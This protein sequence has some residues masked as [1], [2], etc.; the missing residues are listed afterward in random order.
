MHADHVTVAALV[1]IELCLIGAI[2]W[3]QVMGRSEP[4]AARFHAAI[5][6]LLFAS[7]GVLISTDLAELFGFWAIAGAMTYLL[8]AHRWGVDEA[9]TRA[10]V[11]LALPFLTDLSLLC[12]IAWL[13]ARYGTQNLN[14]L[15]PILHTNP[16]WTVRSLVLASVLLFVGI[17]GRLTLWPFTAWFTQTTVTAPPAASVIAQSAWS[18]LAIVLLYRVMPI[19]IASNQ[20]TL[21]ALLA[22]CG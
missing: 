15:L 6:A 1:A 22:V 20:Q 4:G 11:A 17:A 10:R 5:T 7:V 2:G 21:Q 8:L 13:Y 14:T 12:G 16:G 19:F 9:A 18:V 3:H